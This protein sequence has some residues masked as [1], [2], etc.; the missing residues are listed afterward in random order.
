M[1]FKRGDFFGK[2]DGKVELLGYTPSRFSAAALLT[3]ATIIK[4]PL[5][6]IPRRG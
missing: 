6:T 2:K 5:G 1:D 3:R 4:L